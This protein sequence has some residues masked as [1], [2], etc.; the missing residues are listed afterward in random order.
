MS[1]AKPAG[2]GGGHDAEK[3]T[4]FEDTY[5]NPSAKIWSVYTSE[6]IK[7][8]DVLVNGW[9]ENMNG[10][11][12]FATLFSASV[13][14]FILE[15]YAGLTPDPNEQTIALLQQISQQ[16][17][18]IPPPIQA[19]A[20]DSFSP[21]SSTLRVNALW[22]LSLCLALTCALA[23]TLVQQWS[24]IKRRPAPY[25]QARIRTYLYGGLEKFRMAAVVEGIP[26][27][28]HASVFLFF[29]GL[30]DFLWSINREIAWVTL[31]IVAVVGGLY[32]LITILPIFDRQSPFR[33]PLSD[34]CWSL[35]QHFGLLRYRSW[36]RWS[37]NWKRVQDSLSQIQEIIATDPFSCD[38]RKRDICAL[39]WT[40]ESLTEDKEFLPFVEGIPAFCTL[41]DELPVMKSLLAKKD[42]QLL[43]RI[44]A[45]LDVCLASDDPD[46]AANHT[47]LLK[48]LNAIA[49]LS[50]LPDNSQQ[51]FSTYKD[52][53]KPTQSLAKSS[54][55]QI[56]RAANQIAEFMGK[57][58]YEILIS[59]HYDGTDNI[60]KTLGQLGDWSLSSLLEMIPGLVNSSAIPAPG[61]HKRDSLIT[62]T[63]RFKKQV[64]GEVYNRRDEISEM[65]HWIAGV[66][67]HANRP[68]ERRAL[69]ILEAYSY[70][71]E[72]VWR[73]NSSKFTD[74]AR[75]S[76]AL[77]TLMKNRDSELVS[78]YATILAVQISGRFQ[79]D[80]QLAE[81]KDAD[82]RDLAVI[83]TSKIE[84]DDM[85]PLRSGS[86]TLKSKDDLELLQSTI[87]AKHIRLYESLSKEERLTLKALVP[88]ADGGESLGTCRGHVRLFVFLLEHLCKTGYIAGVDREPEQIIRTIT[89]MKPYLNARWSCHRDQERLLECIK[90]LIRTGNK[91]FSGRI[92]DL[93]LA[94]VASTIGDP[95]LIEET[96]RSLQE[97]DQG[98]ARM[99]QF[100]IQLRNAI[101]LEPLEDDEGKDSPSNAD[102]VVIPE[103]PV[104]SSSKFAAAGRK[105]KLSGARSIDTDAPARLAT[106][107]AATIPL[108]PQMVH[109]GVGTTHNQ[110]ESMDGRLGGDESKSE[111]KSK[112]GDSATA[113]QLPSDQREAGPEDNTGEHEIKAHFLTRD[114]ECG[115]GTEGIEEAPFTTSL[116]GTDRHADR[117]SY[118]RR[119]D[120]L[121]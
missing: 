15:S 97:R 61:G 9:M 8:D 65:L 42:I 68:M 91:S 41:N 120:P 79:R 24:A 119:K 70:I 86:I 89:D 108:S 121:A 82:T 37:R 73:E 11:I 36:S 40:L 114:A 69:A 10:I 43:P 7:Y 14:A 92:T 46:K 20:P 38:R 56:S 26:A 81:P 27:L 90:T 25:K 107:P 5:A 64:L 1:D 72:L 33:T 29:A 44:I 49:S 6:A 66:D 105:I 117:T 57:C 13:T 93:P 94:E 76:G 104:A 113:D 53:L 71:I 96:V 80:L 35:C 4:S 85:R 59:N 77:N 116:E 18:G 23:A 112:G 21:T 58:A 50:E 78:Q 62:V 51:F 111:S 12:L 28:L 47:R 16:L 48:C 87:R 54:N 100:C 39:S 19:S 88:G 110:E 99:K 109:T 63:I 83:F 55:P 2:G 84:N 45:L 17:S 101:P 34:F 106:D 118:Q 115:G 22:F 74:F 60:D 75:F 32:I 31:S 102:F 103:I 52:T 3:G 67:L 98:T 95:S 30:V